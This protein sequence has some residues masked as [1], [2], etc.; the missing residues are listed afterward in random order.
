[1]KAYSVKAK[2]GF[3]Y[4]GKSYKGG[5]VF[6]MSEHDLP[7][8][9]NDVKKT[10]DKPEDVVNQNVTTVRAKY[11]FSYQSE[12]RAGGDKFSMA[13]EDLERYK[14][15]IEVVEKKEGTKPKAKKKS[16]K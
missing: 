14:N 5:D 11:S 12:S 9:Q 2:H 1:M 8:Y 4:K 10:S 13:N 6:T 16:K 3:A 15:D 7:R